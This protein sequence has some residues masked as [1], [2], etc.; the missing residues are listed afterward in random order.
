[1]SEKTYAVLFTFLS[2]LS[3]K[4]DFEITLQNVADFMTEH[5]NGKK[6]L[7]KNLKKH[8]LHLQ[9]DVDFRVLIV[10]T[11]GRGNDKH[12][13]Y[14]TL[15][16][17][18]LIFMRANTF[19]AKIIRS[20]FF[21]IEES[22]RE[23]MLETIKTR[24]T[25]EDPKITVK[26]HEKVNQLKRQFKEG[27]SVYAAGLWHEGKR[28]GLRIGKTVNMDRRIPEHEHSYEYEVKEKVQHLSVEEK[29]AIENCFRSTLR[30]YRNPLDSEVYNVTPEKA[31]NVF[32]D[33]DKCLH[34]LRRKHTP[35]SSPNM[36]EPV[37]SDRTFF[38]SE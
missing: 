11:P 23:N 16:T 35:P 25:K 36:P 9:P 22:Y 14:L 6:V 31:A 29:E 27:D 24:L 18:K 19:V 30:D 20:Y 38:Y 7:E 12:N 15:K 33:C 3:L 32:N 26:K 28:I 10:K 13:V 2:W 8:I 34:G 4:K 37:W 21:S 17:F 1:M 5:G